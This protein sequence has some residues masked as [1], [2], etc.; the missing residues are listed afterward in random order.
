M[1]GF[2]ISKYNTIYNKNYYFYCWELLIKIYL[3]QEINY[4]VFF[5]RLKSQFI[6]IYFQLIMIIYYYYYYSRKSD[7]SVGVCDVEIQGKWIKQ[8]QKFKYPECMVDD[9]SMETVEC[10][11]SNEWEKNCEFNHSPCEGKKAE[12]RVWKLQESML[13]LTLMCGRKEREVDN[14]SSEPHSNDWGKEK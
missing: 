8:V 13:I 9:R 1:V 6:L 2:D 12:S 4:I 10:E 14:K 7:Y 5:Y 11:N 3:N